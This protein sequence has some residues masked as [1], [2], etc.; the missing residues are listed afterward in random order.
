MFI[1]STT[2]KDKKQ[3]IKWNT[4]CGRFTNQYS[5]QHARKKPSYLFKDKNGN[6]KDTPAATSC[7]SMHSFP[8][9]Q[10][11]ILTIAAICRILDALIPLVINS[12]FACI[13]HVRDWNRL[14]RLT[15]LQCL[16]NH[17]VVRCRSANIKKR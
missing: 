8:H 15:V 14:K 12:D 9:C 11:N 1:L 10:Q 2:R 5:Q 16:Y 6:K 13:V 4:F 7:F 17:T 3:K